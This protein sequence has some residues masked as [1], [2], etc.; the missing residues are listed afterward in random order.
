MVSTASKPYFLSKGKWLIF[1]TSA[2]VW[3][4]VYFDEVKNCGTNIRAQSVEPIKANEANKAKS[5]N[6]ALSVNS[7]LANAPIVVRQLKH[8]GVD[9]SRKTVI[10]DLTYCWW[11]T[12]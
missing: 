10:G 2:I 9:C 3:L 5:F 12:K 11:V 8:T 1:S 6:R 7:K 4:S